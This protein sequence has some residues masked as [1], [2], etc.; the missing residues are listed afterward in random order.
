MIRTNLRVSI[1]L[2]T[3]G[4]TYRTIRVETCTDVL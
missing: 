3:H 1:E 4:A 2:S